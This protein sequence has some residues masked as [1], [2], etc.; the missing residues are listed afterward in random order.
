MASGWTGSTGSTLGEPSGSVGS[1]TRFI[2]ALSRPRSRPGIGSPVSWAVTSDRLRPIGRLDPGS[3]LTSSTPSL[4]S[5]IAICRPRSLLMVLVV[6]T[7]N[8]VSAVMTTPMMA[9]A[10]SV[11]TRL[12]PSSGGGRFI[13]GLLAEGGVEHLKIDNDV[14]RIAVRARESEVDATDEHGPG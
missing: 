7:K 2:E 3:D 4:A 5:R 12:K 11:S 8:V 10:V 13:V 9:M 1:E 6:E 14:G